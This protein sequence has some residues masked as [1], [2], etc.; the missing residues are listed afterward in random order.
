MHYGQVYKLTAIDKATQRGKYSDRE[1]PVIVD[2]TLD[3][4]GSSEMG[5]PLREG[6]VAR[7]NCLD[8]LEVICCSK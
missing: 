5:A 1:Y 2:E 8:H 3:T 6:F 4:R 7:R